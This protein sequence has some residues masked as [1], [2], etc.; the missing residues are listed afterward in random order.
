MSVNRSSFGSRARV[1]AIVLFLVVVCAVPQMKA[2]TLTDLYSFGPQPDG[3]YPGGVLVFDAA[4]NLYGTTGS[5]GTRGMGAIFKLSP[6]SV[7]GGAWTE[8]VI[9]S[10]TGDS[11]GAT[12]VGGLAIDKGGN[13][14]GTT[15]SFS[16]GGCCGTAFKLKAPTSTGGSWD[17][18]TM[19]AFVGGASDGAYP[20]AGVVVDNKGT[21]YGTTELGGSGTAS[22]CANSS[23]CGTVFKV[24]SAGSGFEETILWN[25]GVSASDGVFPESALLRDSLGNLYGTTVAGGNGG[26]GTLFALSLSKGIY[27][28]TILYSFST[29]Y[30]PAGY[31]PQGGLVMDSEG[32]LWG[33]ATL[34]G[35]AENQCGGTVLKLKPPATVGGSW[36]FYLIHTFRKGTGGGIYPADISLLLDH[37]T[38]TFY[39]ATGAG[40]AGDCGV[41]FRLTKPAVVGGQWDFLPLHDFA[42]AD[43]CYVTSTLLLD[44][45]GNVIGATNRGGSNMMGTVFQITQ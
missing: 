20:I 5:G 30:S 7:P 35:C 17:L 41:V 2:R 29:T 19:H 23:G 32:S 38:G 36:G 14:Y 43:G 25:F 8:S 9:C 12:P 26:T 18:R 16:T 33:T 24:A 3:T 13:L 42:G 1:C 10:F 45:F 21:V 6:P 28:E 44:G 37:T 39:G 4:G 34:G 11:D 27:T 40:G 31:L 22:A 15:Q